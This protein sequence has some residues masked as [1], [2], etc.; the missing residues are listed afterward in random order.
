MRLDRHITNIDGHTVEFRSGLDGF[1]IE[2][3]GVQVY[4]S[5]EIAPTLTQYHTL[6][7]ALRQKRSKDQ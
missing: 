6:R 1:C 5:E 3:N 7:I 4:W 2:L